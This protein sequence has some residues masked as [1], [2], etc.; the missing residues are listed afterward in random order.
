MANTGKTTTEKTA[1]KTSA[2]TIAVPKNVNKA[3]KTELYDT[4]RTALTAPQGNSKKTS[5]VQD[6]VTLMLKE[7]KKNPNSEIGK[8]LARILMNE[9]IIADLDA[10]TDKYLARDID[11]NEYRIMKTLYPEQ[12]QIYNDRFNKRIICIGSRRI[13]KSELAARLLLKDALRPGRCAIYVNLKFEN[14]IRQCYSVCEALVKSLGIPYEKMSKN[15]GE[16]RLTNGSCILFKGNNDRS[17]ADTF[18][19]GKYSLAVVDEVQNQC[20]LQY[21]LDTVL[22]PTIDRDYEDGQIICLG[23]PPRIPHTYCERI[24]KEFKGWKHYG[25]DMSKNPFLKGDLD[26][27]IDRICDE[28]KVTKD[29]PFIQREYFGNWIYDIEARVIKKPLMYIGGTEFVKKEI[30]D[31]GFHCD[32]VY[33]GIDWGGTDYN[34]IVTIAWDH[35]RCKG[36][37]LDH[38]KFNQATATEIIKKCTDSLY[39]AQDILAL[40]G[41]E[42]NNVLY[43]ADHN[44]KSLVFEL[45]NNYNF[46]I[47]LAYKYDKIGGLQILADLLATH[48]YTPTESPL[49]DEYEMSVYKRDEETDAIL[50]EIDDDTFHPDALDALLYASRAIVQLENPLESEL[51]YVEAEA[52]VRGLPED[53][54]DFTDEMDND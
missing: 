4:L 35:K 22:G 34:A 6:Y 45:Q 40:S 1:A 5:F 12:Q 10:Q 39:E 9:D 3:V 2:K 26:T 29:A 48:I 38:Y 24:W 16:I 37:I 28:K 36:Y 43:Y 50:P 13:G 41:S 30:A 20:N 54:R 8:L 7:A 14:A 23:T 32:Y 46:P 49:A 11:F 42:I 33:G 19:G 51:G 47:Q 18:L 31:G 27:I 53:E 52:A 44:I 17:V 25:W 15:E 21:L